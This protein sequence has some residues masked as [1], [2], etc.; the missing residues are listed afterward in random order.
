MS[1]INRNQVGLNDKTIIKLDDIGF[2]NKIKT[3]PK[4]ITFLIMQYEE[5]RK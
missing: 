3:R 4:I 5:Q 2:A 1:K